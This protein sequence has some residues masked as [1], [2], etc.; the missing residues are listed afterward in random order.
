MTLYF[1]KANGLLVKSSVTKK[2]GDKEYLEEYYYSDHK[3]K[4]GSKLARKVAI[5]KDGRLDSEWTITN[6]RLGQIFEPAE[7][8]PPK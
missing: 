7:F 5:W 1:D 3:E 4:E 6:V 2:V 8:A